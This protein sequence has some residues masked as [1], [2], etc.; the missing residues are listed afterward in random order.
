MPHT[1]STARNQTLNRSSGRESSTPSRSLRL[2]PRYVARALLWKIRPF[3]VAGLAVALYMTGFASGD[4]SRG[5]I[6]TIAVHP[7]AAQAIPFGSTVTADMLAGNDSAQNPKTALSNR[8]TPIE[9]VTLVNISE[10]EFIQP[11][12]VST[13][14]S[15]A[16]IPTGKTVV[17]VALTNPQILEFSP[18]GSSLDLYSVQ[19]EVS[20]RIVRSGR[21][22]RIIDSA[23][24]LEANTTPQID[25]LSTT[26]G[27]DSVTVLLAVS[28]SEAHKLAQSSSWEGAFTA[29]LVQ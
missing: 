25:S 13:T 11:S 24:A 29:V 19:T 10:G 15:D 26:I 7:Q 16:L 12:M 21:I 1:A 5:E 20:E 28:E 2:P 22:L 8:W 27:R 6:A 4:K 9:K 14:L 17:A 18:I 23:D 3:A